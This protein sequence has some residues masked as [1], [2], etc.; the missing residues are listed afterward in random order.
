MSKSILILFLAVAISCVASAADVPS[1]I[2][3]PTSEQARN[4]VIAARVFEEIF[5][6]GNF[7]VA[8]QIYAPDFVNHGQHRDASLAEDQAAVHAE[9]AACP[10]LRMTVSQMVAEGDL[11]TV[12]WTFQGTHTGAR[13][14]GLPA[15]GTRIQLR[16]I[17]VWRIVDGKIREEW[18]SFDRLGM[19][20]QFAAQ[21][22]WW[23]MGLL[24]A[25]VLLSWAVCRGIVRAAQIRSRP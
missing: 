25:V 13:Y 5:N 17:T 18:T 12:V 1:P 23:L 9:K 3:V 8:G 20:I 15:T 10:D 24:L 19:F 11:V 2:P 14:Y 7:Q 16:G 22:K 4:K 6:Q 21:L